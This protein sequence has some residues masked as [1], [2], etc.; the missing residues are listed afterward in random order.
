M[1]TA[2]K[3][4]SPSIKLSIIKNKDPPASINEANLIIGKVKK[5]K[6]KVINYKDVNSIGWDVIDADVY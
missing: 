4:S 5:F 3:F 1:I 2:L 6:L